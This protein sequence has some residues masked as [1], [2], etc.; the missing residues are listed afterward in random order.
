LKIV[1]ELLPAASAWIQ[2]LMQPTTGTP[3][4]MA[5]RRDGDNAAGSSSTRMLPES[6]F[7]EILSTIKHIPDFS[8]HLAAV[9]EYGQS[10]LHL[11]VHLRYRQLVHHLVE[12]GAGL[13]IQDIN[14]FTALHCAHLCE[15]DS[16]VTILTRSGAS[17]SILDALGRLPTDLFA[18]PIVGNT[19]VEMAEA[20]D[21]DIVYPSPAP[22]KVDLNNHSRIETKVPGIS[23]WEQVQTTLIALGVP[24]HELGQWQD[25]YLWDDIRSALQ[26]GWDPREEIEKYLTPFFH[27]I[28]D[29]KFRCVAPVGNEPGGGV[30]GWEGVKKDRTINHICRHLDYKAYVCNGECGRPRW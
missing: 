11:A 21:S 5:L 17:L 28:G 14:G 20:A 19:D 4:A 9:N 25:L 29:R 26:T 30:C 27:H 12:W 2:R 13:D 24:H 22:H 10:L 23:Q 7:L 18:R 6:A 3:D 15:D 16:T 8:Q 1:T